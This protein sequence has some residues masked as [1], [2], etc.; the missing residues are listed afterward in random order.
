MEFKSTSFPVSN[1]PI[2]RKVNAPSNVLKRQVEARPM[3]QILYL[4][5]IHAGDF[6]C[7]EELDFYRRALDASFLYRDE[8]L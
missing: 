2:F 8:N 4:S 1:L 6:N 3:Q 5:L 7:I